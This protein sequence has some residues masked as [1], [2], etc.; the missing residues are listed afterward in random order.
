MNTNSLTPYLSDR[1]W[2]LRGLTKGESRRRCGWEVAVTW[3]KYPREG[4]G[5]A[6]GRCLPWTWARSCSQEMD[7]G[8][9]QHWFENFNLLLTILDVCC[10]KLN[11][12]FDHFFS[13]MLSAFFLNLKYYWILSIL[14]SALLFSIQSLNYL[15][16]PFGPS[17]LSP[18]FWCNSQ[19]FI[20]SP[21]FFLSLQTLFLTA[22]SV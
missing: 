9:W 10:T 5:A 14:S 19:I 18:T 15:I 7:C 12:G 22:H 11:G 6:D 17:Y 2:A 3:L 8:S 1:E 20:F 16:L 4:H 21:E 13:V